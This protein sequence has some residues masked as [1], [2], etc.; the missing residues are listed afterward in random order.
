MADEKKSGQPENEATEAAAVETSGAGHRVCRLMPVQFAT[1]LN[2]DIHTR[3][4]VL[5]EIRLTDDVLPSCVSR[6]C[7]LC[8]AHVPNHRDYRSLD[9]F[10]HVTNTR[11]VP[12]GAQGLSSRRRWMTLM[13]QATNSEWLTSAGG[14][15]LQLNVLAGEVLVI[16]KERRQGPHQ[17][18][19]T[20]A[21]C[22][23]VRAGDEM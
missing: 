14:Y 16:V 12:R 4:T 15:H 17:G 11:L 20:E 13:S 18:H 2:D 22:F 10:R 21:A 6:P 23:V 9:G 19:S 1:N 5:H 3:L 7:H 8:A